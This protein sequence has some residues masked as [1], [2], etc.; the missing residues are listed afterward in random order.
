MP[1][2]IY[3]RSTGYGMVVFNQKERT[4][5]IECWP[6]YVD[7]ITDPKGQYSGWPITISQKDNYSKKALGYLP[8]LDFLEVENPM[9]TVIHEATGEKEYTLRVKGSRFR[10]KVFREGT[11]RVQVKASESDFTKTLAG[12]AIDTL[13]VASI[14]VEAGADPLA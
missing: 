6:R 7:P 2:R 8:E 1:A 5:R 10:P 12:L 13:G 14:Q 4:M 3:D 11:F 9:V